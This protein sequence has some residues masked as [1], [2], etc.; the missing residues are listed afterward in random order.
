[1]LCIITTTITLA[2][3]VNAVLTLSPSNAKTI[4]IIALLSI[5]PLKL[6]VKSSD[7]SM[8]P[9]VSFVYFSESDKKV[10]ISSCSV[11]EEIISSCEVVLDA[12]A[13]VGTKY[14]I[15]AINIIM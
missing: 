2:I 3:V 12:L 1:M 10:E 13:V 14:I 5:F 15:I 9:N 6:C 4:F 7:I 8:F 11:W